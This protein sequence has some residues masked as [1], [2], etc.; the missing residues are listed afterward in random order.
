ML[1]SFKHLVGGKP[2]EETQLKNY[3]DILE[4]DPNNVNIRLKLGDLY[5]KLDDKKSAIQEYT[6]AAVQY[7]EDGYLVKAIA[8]NKIIVRLDPSRQEALDRLSSLYFQR[9]IVADSLVESYREAKQ[10]EEEH[11]HEEEREMPTKTVEEGDSSSDEGQLIDFTGDQGEG[12]SLEP[13]FQQIPLLEKLSEDTQEWL[14]QHS[15]I[16][17]FQANEPIFSQESEEE[18]SLFV[19][20]DGKVKLFTK[21]KE[22]RDTLLDI[23]ESGSF[24][25]GLSLLAPM[26]QDQ[27][28][29]LEHTLSAVAERKS[30]VLEIPKSFLAQMIKREPDPSE[31]LLME[32]YKQRISDI[33]LARVALF[34]H[35]EPPERRKIGEHLTPVNVRKGTTIITEGEIGDAMYVIK[36]GQVGV[37]TTL[38]EEQG[39]SVIQTDQERLHLATLQEGDFFG[40]QALITRELRSATII[41]LTDVQLLKFTKHDLA[42]VVKHYPRIGTLLKKYHQQR[43]SDTLESL[44]S[45]W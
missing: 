4:K 26:R 44:K 29:S 32:Y 20:L 8:V 21:D 34:S 13:Y 28:R 12:P 30:L 5:A 6:T 38:V 23:L 27:Q 18:E 3:K 1:D 35:L 33:T 41:A 16:H 2:K 9:G 15:T 42:I 43:I 37:Y 14:S 39:V 36:S 17:T 31:S 40:E 10:K 19:I 24:F 22:S 45:I 25:G 11:V 7:A